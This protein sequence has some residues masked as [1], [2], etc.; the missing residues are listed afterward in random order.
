M[1]LVTERDEE[2]V[3]GKEEVLCLP[4]LIAIQRLGASFNERVLRW[5][6]LWLSMEL[7]FSSAKEP[8]M[9]NT[10]RSMAIKSDSTVPLVTVSCLHLCPGEHT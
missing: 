3:E 5:C 10:I 8:N 2:G 9:N 1:S 6:S 4:K 7:I